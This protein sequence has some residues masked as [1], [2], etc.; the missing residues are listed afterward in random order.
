MLCKI[1]KKTAP[2]KGK[3]FKPP[4]L[5]CFCLNTW[6]SR[7]QRMTCWQ[8]VM[9]NPNVIKGLL[10]FGL[11]V[12]LHSHLLLTY[13]W[14]G[15]SHSFVLQRSRQNDVFPQISIRR[16]LF[17]FFLNHTYHLLVAFR[18]FCVGFI[19]PTQKRHPI[20]AESQQ[21]SAPLKATELSH[22]LVWLVV[23]SVY[24]SGIFCIL[25]WGKES[26]LQRKRSKKSNPS[27]VCA[28]FNGVNKKT[29]KKWC[30]CRF[31]QNVL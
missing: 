9:C 23:Q 8:L 7:L 2:A 10:L 31:E 5:V 22:V 11:S 3:S 12:K 26:E 4:W 16:E 13:D 19:F 15:F 24:I 17:F 25:F 1:C 28:I 21:R 14:E 29:L 6:S 27:N 18:H 30:E 20:M